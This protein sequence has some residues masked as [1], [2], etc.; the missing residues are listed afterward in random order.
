M[1]DTLPELTRTI[2]SNFVNTWYE[3]RSQVIDNILESNIFTL[4]LREYGCMVPQ[5]GGEYITRTVGFGTKSK[6]NIQKGSVLSQS[7][8]DPD[9]MAMWDWRYFA[10]DVNRSL[11]D[12]KKNS[13]PSKIKDYVARRLEQVVESLKQELEVD[14]HR[15]A[16]Y[17]AAPLNINGLLDVCAPLTAN[18]DGVENSD[19]YS[20]GTSNGKISRANTWWRNWAAA[21][22]QSS[23]ESVTNKLGA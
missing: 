9:T 11:V 5:V 1:A 16:S 17:V 6:Q 8:L 18:S 10:I 13:G 2:D 23:T 21:D 22:G 19:S 15:Y 14:L 12:D 3:I 7:E 4:A 20:S